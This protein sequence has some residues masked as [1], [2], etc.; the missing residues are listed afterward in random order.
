M[1]AGCYRLAGYVPTAFWASVSGD[2]PTHKLVCI[3]AKPGVTHRSAG[4]PIQKLAWIQNRMSEKLPSSDA[5]DLPPGSRHDVDAL[6]SYD[7]F[8]AT[9]MSSIV[10]D[11][12]YRTHRLG[13]MKLI[14]TLKEKCGITKV[15]YA[16]ANITSKKD[17]TSEAAAITDDL[18]A[19]SRSKAFCLVYPERVVSSA[20]VETGFALGHRKP[21]I[22]FV[23][24]KRDLPYLLTE[25]EESS[26]SD[27]IP[28]VIVHQYRSFD[29]LI[30]KMISLAPEIRRLLTLC[31]D[32]TKTNR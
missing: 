10:E 8:L 16:A 5:V 13:V 2:L 30:E 28:P 15:Y 1:A 18:R 14:D 12:E 27:L 17:F 24:N 19:L 3:A 6:G 22:L 31:S 25:A 32:L 11:R 29:D 4:Q 7:L 9:P 21:C 20:L 23:R 26:D